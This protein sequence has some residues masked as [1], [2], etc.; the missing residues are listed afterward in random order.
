VKPAGAGKTA[1]HGRILLVEDGLDNQRLI[2][3]LLRKAG[4][5]VTAVEDGRA[6]IEAAQAAREAGKPFD[7][8]LMDM[9]MPVMDGYKATRQLR[10]RG[11]T[12]PIV[13]LT[14]HAMSQDR[15]KCLE[16]GCD[17]YLPKPFEHRALLETVA[18]HLKASVP[19]CR[20]DS[21]VY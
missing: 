9:Q 2:S 14:A 1:L 15:Q 12:A 10:K 7:V 16:A 4:A 20:R 3:L 8:I 21:V 19:D 6:A 5:Q 11:Y 13:A 17:D 18:R